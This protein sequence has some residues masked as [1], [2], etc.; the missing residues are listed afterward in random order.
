MTHFQTLFVNSIPILFVYKF[1]I[2]FASSFILTQML[3]NAR[4]TSILY[5]PLLPRSL[6]PHLRCLH[7]LSNIPTTMSSLYHALATYIT[8]PSTIYSYSTNFIITS[9]PETEIIQRFRKATRS[10]RHV[11]VD[12]TNSRI[13]D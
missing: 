12:P 7:H 3:D 8:S 5:A 11:T 6:P 1:Q 13:L 10:R 9:R 2:L 4:S